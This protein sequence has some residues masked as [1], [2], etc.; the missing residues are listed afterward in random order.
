M[1]RFAR[2]SNLHTHTPLELK[3]GGFEGKVEAGDIR[4]ICCATPKYK[5]YL[6]AGGGHAQYSRNRGRECGALHVVLANKKLVLSRV[7]MLSRGSIV[8]G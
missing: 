6:P 8:G 5:S 2:I 3:F 1:N 4:G 7:F